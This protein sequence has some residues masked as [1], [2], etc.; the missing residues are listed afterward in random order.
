MNNVDELLNKIKLAEKGLNLDLS[1]GEDL[2][3]GI[4]NLIS[5]EEHLFFSYQKTKDENFLKMLSEVREL[6]KELL[7]K[8]VKRKDGEIWC[9]SKHLLA[10]SMRL[11]EVGTKMLGQKKE[12]EAKDLFNKAYKLYSLFWGINLNVEP[13]ENAKKFP[14]EILEFKKD[15]QK[16]TKENRSSSIFDKLE[17]IVT[18]ALNCC[19]E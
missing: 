16:N 18:K 13:L 15:D 4:M 17:N 3:I 9:I 19:R 2:S 12:Q 6:R 14:E 11:I 5:I 8:I 7:G 10:S 1:S